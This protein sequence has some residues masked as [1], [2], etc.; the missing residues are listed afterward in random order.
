[1][2]SFLF[3]AK[4]TAEQAGL[5]AHLLAFVPL[6]L[7]SSAGAAELRGGLCQVRPPPNRGRME[8]AHSNRV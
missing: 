4:D 3:D 1:M 7:A 8:V 5:S 2:E 6:I